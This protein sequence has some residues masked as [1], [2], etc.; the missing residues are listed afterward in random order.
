[1]F[2]IARPDNLCLATIDGLYFHRGALIAIQNAFMAPR[3]VR[4]ILSHD[5][6]AIKEFEVLERRNPIFDGVTTGLVAGRDFFYMANIQDDK[7]T[8]YDPITMLKLHS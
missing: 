6:R 5:L 8:G 7:E 4:F 3:V 2:L 1:L